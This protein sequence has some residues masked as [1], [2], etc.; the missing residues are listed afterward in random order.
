M[1]H[2][3]RAMLMRGDCRS[4]FP[5]LQS[6]SIDMIF[7]DPPYNYAQYSTGNIVFKHR[8]DINNDIA[9][10]DYAF[11]PGEVAPV[12]QRLLSPKGNLFVFCGRNTIGTWHMLL[13]DQFDSCQLFTWHKPNPT[14]Q[15]RKTGFLNS[16][17]HVL[18][19]WN[20]GHI[21]NF[22]TQ[23]EMHN[24]RTFN[25]CAG[26]ERIKDPYHPTQKP[27]ALLRHLISIASNPGSIVLDPYMG[28]GSIGV[29]ALEL[30]RR[31]VGMELHNEY[32]DAA[33]RRIDNSAGN[34]ELFS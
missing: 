23:K 19:F 9:S 30:G 11:D 18:C 27:I 22:L 21:W 20:K 24:C 5:A 28:L 16:T 12:F 4:Y 26:K 10:W 31:Y 15:I 34:L 33:R 14:P 3:S 7:T 25:K 6:E 17:E 1:E 32:F 29:A 2:T 13:D 8:K